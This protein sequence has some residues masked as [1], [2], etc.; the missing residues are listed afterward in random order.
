[1]LDS[2]SVITASTGPRTPILERPS[3]P[4]PQLD[5]PHSAPVASHD[6]ER[7]VPILTLPERTNKRMSV[8]KRSSLEIPRMES[9]DLGN[10][11]MPRNRAQSLDNPNPYAPIPNLRIF[12]LT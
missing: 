11:S 9:T 7:L 2:E 4:I 10:Q 8:Q 6:S 1:M 5:P 12:R 3:E